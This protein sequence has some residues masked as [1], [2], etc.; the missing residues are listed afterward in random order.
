MAFATTSLGDATA[1]ESQGGLRHT[2][3]QPGHAQGVAISVEARKRGMRRSQQ[4][5]RRRTRTINP[6]EAGASR[7]EGGP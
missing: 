2:G 5:L 7:K 3:S 1:K 4:R 6:K